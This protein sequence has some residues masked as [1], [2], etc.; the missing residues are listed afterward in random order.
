MT[1]NEIIS[2]FIKE[3]MKGF[4]EVYISSSKFQTDI[5]E[6]ARSRFNIIH[7]PET[8]IRAWRDYKKNNKEYLIEETKMPFKTKEKYYRIYVL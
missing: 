6:F 1:V 4:N 2:C 5:T 7:T 8:Y 3:R